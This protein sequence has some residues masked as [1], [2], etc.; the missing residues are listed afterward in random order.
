MKLYFGNKVLRIGVHS[1]TNYPFW[2]MAFVTASLLASLFL[3]H[4]LVYL[5]FFVCI[6]RMVKYD[7]TVFSVDYCVLLPLS[8]L[9]RT[10]G[11]MALMVYLSILA[12]IWYLFRRGIR[13][14]LALFVTFLL[15]IYLLLRFETGNYVLVLSQMVLLYIML[16]RQDTQ[17]AENSVK[18]F[19]ISLFISSLYALLFRHTYQIQALRGTEVPA[20]FGSSYYRFQG[21]F[22]DPNYFNALL[23]TSIAILL[24]LKDLQRVTVSFFYLIGG[25]FVLFGLLTYSKSF[26]LCLIL[27]V[28]IYVLWQ[29]RDRKVFWASL[30]V[31]AVM[32]AATVMLLLEFTPLMVILQRFT[33]SKTLSSM[34]T[35]RTDVFLLYWAQVTKS[36]SNFFIGLGQKAYRIYKDPHNLYLEIMYHTGLVGLSLFVIYVFSMIREARKK[37]KGQH[38][39]NFFSKYV[40]MIVVLTVFCALHGIFSVMLYGIFYLVFLSI[41]LIKKPEVNNP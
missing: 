39:R 13:V 3:S 9:F 29:L 28:G 1:N 17:S 27:L 26:F 37:I 32:L 12:V 31:I 35:G 41:M 14:N 21:L 18:G 2:G 11:G 40:V 19:C 36:F 25:S 24:K 34:T 4:Y 7:L 6:Y 10:S 16:P 8:M 5:A 33:G 20:F 22:A 23:I 38:M 15:A 30:I